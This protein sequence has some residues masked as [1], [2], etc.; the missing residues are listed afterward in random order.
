MKLKALK[1]FHIF[2]PPEHDIKIVKGQD[3][4]DIPEKFIPNLITEGVLK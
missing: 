1:D 3:I 4:S 2:M